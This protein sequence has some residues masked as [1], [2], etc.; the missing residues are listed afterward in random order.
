MGEANDNEVPATMDGVACR[1]RV[2]GVG[3]P[4]RRGAGGCD[5]HDD[6]SFLPGFLSLTERQAET[7]ERGC[8]VAWG[9]D[10]ATFP[11]ARP[12]AEVAGV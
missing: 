6:E 10:E 11:E 8:R 4:D 3:P 1:M 9:I 5:V 2:S 12:C 7:I